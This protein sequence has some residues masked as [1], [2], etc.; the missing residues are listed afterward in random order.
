MCLQTVLVPNLLNCWLSAQETHLGISFTSCDRPVRKVFGNPGNSS[1]SP[2]SVIVTVFCH[3]HHFQN[4]GCLALW[5]KCNAQTEH[6]Q[7]LLHFIPLRVVQAV[8][9]YEMTTFTLEKIRPDPENNHDYMGAASMLF[10]YS[11]DSFDRVLAYVLRAHLLQD[12]ME[13]F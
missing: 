4:D 12:N 2:V 6:T 10:S 5:T 13:E 3:F 11:I 7:H 9:K 1:K 8:R